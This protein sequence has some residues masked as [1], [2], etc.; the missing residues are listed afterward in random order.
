MES[1]QEISKLK[2]PYGVPSAVVANKSLRK[3]WDTFL[4]LKHIYDSGII[5]SYSHFSAELAEECNIS[6]RTFWNRLKLMKKYKLVKIDER[7][8]VLAS[9]SSLVQKYKL[10]NKFYYIKYEDDAKIEFFLIAKAIQEAKKRKANMF[11]VEVMKHELGKELLAVCGTRELSREAVLST[12]I[13]AFINPSLFQYY[14][15]ELLA[16]LNADNNY[17]CNRIALML[18]CNSASSASYTK[19]KL[20]NNNLIKVTHRKFDSNERSRYHA[21]GIVQYSHRNKKTFLTIPDLIQ[22]L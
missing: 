11:K 6:E 16:S 8:I 9:W 14:E 3:A 10:S 17:N 1:T 12:S 4:W 5:T 18:G 22:V 2:I 19:R 20:I 15:L 21:S 7:N 13:N